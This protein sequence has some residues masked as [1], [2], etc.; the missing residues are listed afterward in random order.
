MCASRFST[1]FP[2]DGGDAGGLCRPKPSAALSR[3]S[4][5]AEKV[6][7]SVF[8]LAAGVAPYPLSLPAKRARRGA[9]PALAEG[10]FE[11][12]LGQHRAQPTAFSAGT[13]PR[14]AYASLRLFSRRVGL[15]EDAA[16]TLRAGRENRSPV[17]LGRVGTLTVARVDDGR[18]AVGVVGA[19]VSILRDISRYVA[20]AKA[21]SAAKRGAGGTWRCV[22]TRVNRAGPSEARMRTRRCR[23]RGKHPHKMKSA[24][25]WIAAKRGDRGK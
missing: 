10:R 13:A 17:H 7:R 12:W 5:L 25:A 9:S 8:R 18:G 4:E 11:L 1:D 6:P 16:G 19:A 22:A 21:G 24:K 15:N 2:R 3:P 20:F 14:A 23:D